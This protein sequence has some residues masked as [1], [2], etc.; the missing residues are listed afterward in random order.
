MLDT[1]LRH[2]DIYQHWFRQEVQARRIKI[3]WLPTNDMPADGLTKA[4]SRQ[5]HEN[6]IKQLNLVDIKL[7]LQ[8]AS[9]N[10]QEAEGVCQPT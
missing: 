1:K 7:R 2:I 6:F 9:C 5:R 8:P 3:N 4:L 10:P